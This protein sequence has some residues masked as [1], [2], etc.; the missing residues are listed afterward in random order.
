MD[1][2]FWH[3][4]RCSKSRQALELLRE[5][6]VEPTVVLYLV[7]PPD[8]RRIEQVL[9]ALGIE[10]RELMRT[11]EAPYQELGLGDETLSRRALVQAMAQHP[12]LIER[13]IAICGPRAVIGR[14]PERV[15]ELIE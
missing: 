10:P 14:P 13:P 8:P 4:P 1:F 3:N 12:I 11:Q 5:R 6:G 7:D 9:V 15:L 2:T